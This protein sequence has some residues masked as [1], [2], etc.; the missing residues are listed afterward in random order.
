[1]KSIAIIIPAIN[2]KAPVKIALELA[3]KSTEDFNVTVFTLNK[4][5][6]HIKGIK[7]EELN[8][9]NVFKL[10]K[11]DYIHTHCCKPDFLGVFL[12]LFF[13]HPKWISTL[14]C[15]PHLEFNDSKHKN[16]ML[17]FSKL[18]LKVINSS[19]C[20]VLLNHSLQEK[21]NL[22]RTVVIYNG[23]DIHEKKVDE[24]LVNEIVEFV[25]NRKVIGSYGVIREVKGFRQI[26][27]VAKQTND[28][29]YIIIG[30]GPDYED[31]QR[32]IVDNGLQEKIL[33]LGFRED[34]YRFL[35][36][37][38]LFLIPSYSEGF[39]VALIESLSCGKKVLCSDIDIFKELSCVVSIELFENDN[40]SSLKS[41]IYKCLN[42]KE[43]KNEIINFYKEN[44]SARSMYKS[45]KKMYESLNE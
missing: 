31:Y 19:S 27:S 28:L 26:L 23:I 34:A 10:R 6:N 2:N 24:N 32:Y 36:F 18:W 16:L 42:N 30:D 25:N 14:H 45:Y 15:N 38:D 1:M 22:K 21:L 17:Y 37:F 43:N 4:S 33:L 11:F 39:P 8:I 41:K 13:K 3:L 44:L 5:E 7:C 20:V 9:F 35:P 12:K 29:C 40:Q